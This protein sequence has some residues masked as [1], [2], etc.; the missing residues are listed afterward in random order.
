MSKHAYFFGDGK[1]EGD[2]TMRE[3]LGGKGAGLA[4]MTSAGLPVPPGFTLTTKTCLSFFDNDLS[5]PEAVD[6]Q[7][8]EHLGTL[9]R[10]RGRKLG[11]TDKPLLLSV[12]SG[13]AISMPGMM[14]SVLNLGLND[15]TVVGLHKETGNSWY[16][17]DCYRR[18]IQ[19]F[20][21]VVLGIGIRKFEDRIS[22]IKKVRNVEKDT[23]MTTTD[24]MRLVDEYKGLVAEATGK[25]FPQDTLAQLRLA[26]DAVY[27]SWF[28]HEAKEY[29]RIE[30]IPGDL[31]TAVN[32][33]AMVFGNLSRRSG[34]GVGFTRNPA[35]GE[36]K[37]YGEYL[38]NAQGEDVVA[39]LR[40]PH[41][42]SDLAKEMPAVHAQLAG[43]AQ[44]LEDHYREVQDF[45]FTIEEGVLYMLQ[46][47][48]GKRTGRA[49]IRIAMD[50]LGE[51]KVNKTEAL[52]MVEPRHVEGFMHKIFVPGQKRDVVATGLPAS[53]GAATGRIYFHSEDAVA[54]AADGPVI[55]VRV[56]TSPEDISGMDAAEGIRPARGGMT[57]HAAVVARQMGTCC[58][59]GCAEAHVDED[60]RVLVANN[61]AF[62]EGAWISLDGTSGEVIAGEMDLSAPDLSDPHFKAFMELA[63]KFRTLGIRTNADQPHDVR[64]AR[65]FGAEGIG[66]C[67]TEHMFFDAERLPIVQKMI[68]A[69]ETEQREASLELLL[70]FQR[71]D[72]DAIFEAMAGLPCTIR[73][74]D[75]P[76]HEFLPRMVDLHKDLNAL[77]RGLRRTDPIAHMIELLGDDEVETSRVL[78]ANRKAKELHAHRL[79]LLERSEA[80]HELNPMLGHRGCRLGI[81]YPEITRMQARAILEAACDVTKRGIEV[82]PEIMVPLV[83]DP[84][85]LK[86]QRALI[87]GVAAKVFADKGMTIDYKIGTM[88]ELPRACLVADEIAKVADFFS[89]GTNDLTQTTFGYSRDDAGRFISAYREQGLLDSDPFASIDQ[90]GVGQLVDIAVKKGRGMKPK[91]KVGICGEHG[92]DPAS[93]SF[94]ANTGLDYVSCSPYRVPVAR[95]AAAQHAI[96]EA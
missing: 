29:R 72:F 39:G 55:L 27:G 7:M 82:H 31:G 5:C 67:R 73:L 75:P 13:A 88:I 71:A 58:V 69:T 48:K 42:L 77:E 79:A 61:R 28:N 12:R 54:A 14:D 92:G 83:G 47:R 80:L 87:E 59:A 15:E 20:G 30:G 52:M 50:M 89:F 57:S 25:D 60:A 66:L 18:F 35:T 23:D 93:I 34:S 43:I 81:T 44:R 36:D 68:M 6:K 51:G 63:D 86:N 53:P 11:D 76:L 26:R 85:E 40:T 70:P 65:E 32:V 38:L 62:K 74:L 90:A 64:Q 84:G 3:L 24:L 8:L 33:Q 16:A 17:W 41:E 96:S 78:R 49:A 46:T 45:E 37:L 94:F 2:G 22:A 95:L 56:E 19:M 4:E 9:E 10:L 91:L 21:N 1:A